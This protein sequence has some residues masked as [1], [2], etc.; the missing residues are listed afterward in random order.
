M[1]DLPI[2]GLRVSEVDELVQQF[3]DDDEVV[4]DRFLLD[5]LEVVAEDLQR[6]VSKQIEKW[7]IGYN[8]QWRHA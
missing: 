7:E 4:A 5:V 6:K 8:L 3:V 1:Q 2:G